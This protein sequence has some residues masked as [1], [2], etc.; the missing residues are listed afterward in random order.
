MFVLIESWVDRTIDSSLIFYDISIYWTSN[1]C[2]FILIEF[3][4]Y[5]TIDSSLNLPGLLLVFTE[6]LRVER[7]TT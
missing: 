6:L 5:P 2:M 3:S 7:Q 1:S 4:V